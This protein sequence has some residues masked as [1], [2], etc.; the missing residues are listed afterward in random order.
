MNPSK[1]IVVLIIAALLLAII[2]TRADSR[3]GGVA[4]DPIVASFEREFNHQGTPS[5]AATGAAID[6]DKLYELVN[7]PLQSPEAGIKGEL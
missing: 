4:D 6:S 2:S 7:K 3:V 1:T 5:A